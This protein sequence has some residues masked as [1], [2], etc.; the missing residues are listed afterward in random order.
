MQQGLRARVIFV[1]LLSV[2]LAVSTV[3]PT[4]AGDKGPKRSSSRCVSTQAVAHK[5]PQISPPPIK[6]PVSNR[7]ITLKTNCGDIVI[8]ADGRKTPLTVLAISALAIGGFFD[9]TLCH[10][11]TTSGIY[12]LQCGDPTATG[13]GGPLFTY[14]DENLPTKTEDN[15]PEGIVAMANT[16]R[17]STNGSQF[18]LVYEDTTLPPTYTRW[19]QIIRGL[20]IV[21]AVAAQGVV[22]GGSDGTPKLTI[23]I[24]SVVV[25]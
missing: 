24:E 13:S 19:G 16:G 10:R 15:Y 17:P 6:F 23:A 9:H 11:L 21:K 1:A 5:E 22:G 12:V 2:A 20:D 4:F 25:R 8:L 7:I 14:R 18:F 3:L